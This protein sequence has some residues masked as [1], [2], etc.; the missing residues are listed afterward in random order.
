MPSTLLDTDMIVSLHGPPTATRS[1]ISKNAASITSTIEMPLINES[2]TAKILLLGLPTRFA[3]RATP[4]MYLSCPTLS[5]RQH[6]SPAWIV[7]PASIASPALLRTG[8]DSPVKIDSST[9]I[10]PLLTVES[11]GT[12]AP[13]AT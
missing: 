2:S 4:S 3:M 8:R 9:S 11:A 6:A 5:A 1:A 12:C 10:S 13:A 7:L